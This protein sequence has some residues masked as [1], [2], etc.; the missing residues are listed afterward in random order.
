MTVPLGSRFSTVSDTNPVNYVITAPFKE[1]G[2]VVPGSYEATCE[3]LGVI[4]NEYSGNLINITFIQGL[5][6]ATMSTTLVPA[7]DEE[8]DEELRTRY[9]ES[10]KK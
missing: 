9:F 3:E 7:R 4:G 8:T 10:L 5:A 1:D 2:V 6:A